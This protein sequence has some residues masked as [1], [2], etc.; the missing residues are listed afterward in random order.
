MNR[1]CSINAAN[2]SGQPSSARL[3]PA[4]PQPRGAHAADR[5]RG[6]SRSGSHSCAARGRGADAESPPPVLRNVRSGHAGSAVAAVCRI[7]PGP[8]RARVCAGT[9]HRDR[10]PRRRQSRR[11]I[12]RTCGPMRA[13]QGGHHRRDNDAG[14][15]RGQ[16]G[17]DDDPHGDGRA[18]GPGGDGPR[19]EPATP[20][21]KSH[22]HVPDDLGPGGETA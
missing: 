2:S 18:R 9:E 4:I 1:S 20:R 13:G 16:T 6:H 21:R 11:A 22:R 5:A 19:G 14:R 8:A 7:L 12:L 17:D 10:I 15:S 3:P